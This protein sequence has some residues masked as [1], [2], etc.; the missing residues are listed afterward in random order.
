MSLAPVFGYVV[1]RITTPREKLSYR[2]MLV[3]ETL[4]EEKMRC[5]EESIGE[6]PVFQIEGYSFT[7]E[8]L[9]QDNESV[10]QMRPWPYT[11]C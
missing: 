4:R 7:V 11:L 2:V 6:N 3:D 9:P 1:V 8:W 5:V 10:L